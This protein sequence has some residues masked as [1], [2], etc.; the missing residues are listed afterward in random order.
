[1]QSKGILRFHPIFFFTS[2]SFFSLLSFATLEEEEEEEEDTVLLKS[3]RQSRVT[4]VLDVT[5]FETLSR[6]TEVLDE[7]T[8]RHGQFKVWVQGCSE[9][10]SLAVDTFP[11]IFLPFSRFPASNLTNIM[12]QTKFNRSS[13]VK[14]GFFPCSTDLLK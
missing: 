8:F 13:T 5:N 11:T 14:N 1:M 3:I 9:Q 6:I 4:G 10:V 12:L 2:R 7:Y